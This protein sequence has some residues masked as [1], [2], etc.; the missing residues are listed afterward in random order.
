M[1]THTANFLEALLFGYHDEGAPEIDGKTIYD[2][3]PEFV[4]GVESFIAGFLEY[5]AV[6]DIEPIDDGPSFGGNVYFSLSDHGVGFWDS[7]ETEHL[8]TALIEYSGGEYRF[9]SIDLSENEDGKL[10]LSFIPSA[11]PDYRAKLF[12]VSHS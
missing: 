8:N 10:D 2:F 3:S 9:E 12:T 7:D 1:N 5:L 6:R 4:Q 11:L